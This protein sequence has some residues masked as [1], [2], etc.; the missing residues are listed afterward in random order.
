[1][2]LFTVWAIAWCDRHI[3]YSGGRLICFFGAPAGD[4]SFDHISFP[5]CLIPTDNVAIIWL[6][7][8]SSLP[9]GYEN[10]MVDLDFSGM[11][12]ARCEGTITVIN[13]CL[14]YDGRSLFMAFSHTI[15]CRFSRV[16]FVL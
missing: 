4:A 1:M 12:C 3:I 16:F 5:C 9:F 6:D 10:L 13:D 15:L 8:I 14:C 7:I 11:F 2:V